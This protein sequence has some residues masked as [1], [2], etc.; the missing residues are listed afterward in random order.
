MAF[1]YRHPF[2]VPCHDA[3][4]CLPSHMR[5]TCRTQGL[6]EATA[7]RM[8]AVQEQGHKALAGIQDRRDKALAS[9]KVRLEG[10][11]R[12]GGCGGGGE[13]G[14]G[15]RWVGWVGDCRNGECGA[16]AMP[17]TNR[18]RAGGG[19]QTRERACR[20]TRGVGLPGAHAGWSRHKGTAACSARRSTTPWPRRTRDT[21]CN[22]SSCGSSTG[23][24]MPAPRPCSRCGGGLRQG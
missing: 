17:G 11:V 3:L 1:F 8:E 5:A 20:G 4:H 10:R 7:K 15:G 21:S 2:T 9:L 16:N 13:R 24:C 22:A 18:W 12:W 6:S 14:F 23:I 19:S